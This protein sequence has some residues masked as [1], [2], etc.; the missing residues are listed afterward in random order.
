MQKISQLENEKGTWTKRDIEL[1]IQLEVLIRIT[2]VQEEKDKAFD[3]KAQRDKQ[4][5]RHFRNKTRVRK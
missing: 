5:D 3:G 1:S 2:K 4:K